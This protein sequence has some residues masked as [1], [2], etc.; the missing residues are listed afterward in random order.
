MR[1]L[2]PLDSAIVFQYQ[3]VIDTRFTTVVQGNNLFHIGNFMR[4][5]PNSSLIKR[6]KFDLP[7][8]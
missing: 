3:S 4:K 6:R 8:Y 5:E 7:Y 1:S 2:K